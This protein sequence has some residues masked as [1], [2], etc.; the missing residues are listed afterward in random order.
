MTGLEG[1][2]PAGWAESLE[3]VPEFILGT[4]FLAAEPSLGFTLE[5][6]LGYTGRD[7]PVQVP[8][9]LLLA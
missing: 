8:A 3:A 1:P 6:K 2:R 9:G 5:G 7:R 4:G